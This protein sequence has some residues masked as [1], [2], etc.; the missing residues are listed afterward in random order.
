M[1]VRLIFNMAYLY[2]SETNDPLVNIATEE[3][4]YSQLRHFDK[5]YMLWI[6]SPSVFI[7]K[8]Q[9]PEAETDIKY[10]TDNNIPII[11]R[12][13]G[14]GTVYHDLGNL[15]MTVIE[16][17]QRKGFGFDMSLF[18]R[19]VQSLL[20]KFGVQLIRSPRGDLRYNGIKVAGSAQAMKQGRMLYHLCML[21]DADL[22]VLERVLI[23]D[24]TKF[25]RVDSVRSKV[26][27][28]KSLIPQIKTTEDF[29]NM[30]ISEIKSYE[31]ELGTIRLDDDNFRRYI[32]DSIK[33][34]FGNNSWTFSDI[35]IKK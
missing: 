16:N 5:I 18:T 27:N 2:I 24:N 20:K 13:S 26:V 17:E 6:N 19:S 8:Y 7:G 22:S 10:T 32:S 35:G 25:S 34:K 3:Y 4:L 28:I 31:E 21:F 23:G 14:G 9:C 1:E 29:M 12:I 11:R 15:N 33:S 30:L